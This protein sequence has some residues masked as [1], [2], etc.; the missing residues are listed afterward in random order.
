MDKKYVI[1]VVVAL[2]AVGGGA[3]YSGT[4]YEKNTLA[5]QAPVRGSA[6]FGQGGGTNRQ[7]GQGRPQGMNG[8]NVNGDFVSG[9]VLSKDD[10][11]ITV[12]MRDG[13]SK[14]IYF[15]GSTAIGKAVD[16]TASDLNQG[17]EVVVNGKNNTDGSL[18]AQN[19]QIR[20]AQPVGQPVQP[21]Q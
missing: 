2:I 1:A 19:I 8:Q 9:Q 18:T 11:S 21:Q 15:S 6:G 20:P 10:K 17:E 13:S 16:G 12:K 4:V 3:F 14:I 7:G 5:S